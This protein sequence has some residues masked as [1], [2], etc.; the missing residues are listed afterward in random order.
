MKNLLPVCLILSVALLPVA[1]AAPE[2]QRVPALAGPVPPAA[3]V[4]PT[5]LNDTTRPIG[6]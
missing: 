5:P 1:A 2:V 4:Q 6:G 3:P